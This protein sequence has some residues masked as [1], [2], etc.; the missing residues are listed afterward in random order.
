MEA[1]ASWI[2]CASSRPTSSGSSSGARRCWRPR[3]W[4]PPTSRGSRTECGHRHPIS[5]SGG[6][7][8]PSSNLTRTAQEQTSYTKVGNEPWG[9]PG[10]DLAPRPKRLTGDALGHIGDVAL[11]DEIIGPLRERVDDSGERKDARLWEDRPDELGGLF[12]V[13]LGHHVVEDHHIGAC[14]G[15]QDD[16]G[17]SVLGDTHDVE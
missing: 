4:G 17:L 16:P 1:R 14:L 13:D 15:R 2:C 7:P 11:L 6:G 3:P 9:A 10:A 12:A 5:P 8:R